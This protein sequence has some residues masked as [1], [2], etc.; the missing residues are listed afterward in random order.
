MGDG[1][2]TPAWA[3]RVALREE[4]EDGFAQPN[5]GTDES[6]KNAK[7]TTKF[8]HEAVSGYT[9][10]GMSKA[11]RDHMRVSALAQHPGVAGH[12][13]D[14]PVDLFTPQRSQRSD[15]LALCLSA[16]ASLR[17]SQTPMINGRA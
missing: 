14:E 16:G 2:D 3:A 15:M 12:S 5:F 10:E 4:I 13:K 8:T 11:T 6:P 1:Q 9:F 17:S 7:I